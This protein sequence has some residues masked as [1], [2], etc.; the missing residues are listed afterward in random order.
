M[1]F[2][3]APGYGNLPNGNAVPT[4]FDNKIL[5]SLKITSV[6]DEITNDNYSGTIRDKGDTVRILKQPIVTVQPYE[7]GI[8]L[9][10][11]DIVD[12]D[13]SGSAREMITDME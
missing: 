4:I 6:V 13:L 3:A 12:N 9:M 5:R 8:N 11:Q 2:P 7:R 10:T 1:T